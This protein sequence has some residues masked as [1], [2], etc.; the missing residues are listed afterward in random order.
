MEKKISLT[1]SLK[2]AH[3]KSARHAPMLLYRKMNKKIFILQNTHKFT[4]QRKVE[5]PRWRQSVSE[6]QSP[7]PMSH[8]HQDKVVVH[9]KIK[10][11]TINCNIIY[12]KQNHLSLWDTYCTYILC[13]VESLQ[14]HYFQQRKK[15][16]KQWQNIKNYN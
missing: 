3:C 6:A 14:K 11:V 1:L 7:R 16:L 8:R 9:L 2:K 4:Y 10:E 12:A 5:I 15:R 13:I